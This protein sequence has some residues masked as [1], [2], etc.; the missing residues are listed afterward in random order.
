MTEAP[1][2]K[3]IDNCDVEEEIRVYPDYIKYNTW[4]WPCRID[5]TKYNYKLEW[6]KLLIKAFDI[7]IIEFWKDYE[8]TEPFNIIKNWELNK[9]VTQ[10]YR[11]W[12]IKNWRRIHYELKREY[13]DDLNLQRPYTIEDEKE[14]LD[15]A[16]WRLSYYKSLTKRHEF[17]FDWHSR[18]SWKAKKRIINR[19][20]R[21]DFN[22]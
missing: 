8:E 22:E 18:Y 6:D 1:Y 17:K 19:I 2:E 11:K 15:N 9:T 7:S 13:K 14:H 12:Y 4:C 20:K 10:Q 21:K 3:F 5:Y 16:V